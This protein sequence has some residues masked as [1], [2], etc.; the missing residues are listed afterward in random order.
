MTDLQILLSVKA[1][2]K[3]LSCSTRHIYRL[4]DRGQMPKP[5]HLGALVRW[6]RFEI[7]HWIA[8]GCPRVN[9]SSSFIPSKKA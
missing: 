3:L 4:V 5:V 1:V 9:S 8:E 6:N 2:A 7:E